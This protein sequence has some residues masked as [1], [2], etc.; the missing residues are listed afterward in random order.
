[1][2]SVFDVKHFKSNHL[3]EQVSFWDAVA[4][5]VT[6]DYEENSWETNVHRQFLIKQNTSQKSGVKFS[7]SFNQHFNIFMSKH[8][9]Y[10]VKVSDVDT[11]QFVASVFSCIFF[12]VQV[13]TNG[14][15][16]V[17]TDVII[18]DNVIKED[19]PYYFLVSVEKFQIR[20]INPKDISK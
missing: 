14:V 18:G 15:G 8:T 2:I 5:H 7:E 13:A 19:G 11:I 16:F 10:G 9:D 17:I 4:R 1:M 3:R 12:I 20:F 6:Q